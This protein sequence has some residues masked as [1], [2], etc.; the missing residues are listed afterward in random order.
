[1]RYLKYLFLIVVAVAAVLLAIAN[2]GPVTLRWLP[3]GVG[4]PGA[5]GIPTEVTLPIYVALF[6][7]VF[8]GIL[9]G[10]VLE[11]LRETEHRRKERLYKKEAARLDA[12]NRRLAQKAGEEDHD[13][14]GL[15]RG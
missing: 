7:A 6:L 4:V 8:L 5:E 11:M 1:M 10:L 14:L 12:E 3:E 13:I 9:I 15:T 2:R